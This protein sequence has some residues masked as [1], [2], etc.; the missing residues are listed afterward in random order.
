[1][2]LKK[3]LYG[4]Q[5]VGHLRGNERRRAAPAEGEQ[6]KLNDK[7]RI[8]E[9]K[10]VEKKK[11]LLSADPQLSGAVLMLRLELNGRS[12]SSPKLTQR[13]KTRRPEFASRP[14]SFFFMGFSGTL[15]FR[16]DA[17]PQG[18]ATKR[19]KN[20]SLRRCRRNQEVP[21]R[22]FR[23]HAIWSVARAS[24]TLSLNWRLYRGR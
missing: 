23:D 6:P 16:S 21:R 13:K 20:A 4:S 9:K 11:D 2:R 7:A 24:D 8:V 1:M 15:L 17:Q 19:Q 5:G 10:V 22:L 18:F 3:C 12:C 14:R